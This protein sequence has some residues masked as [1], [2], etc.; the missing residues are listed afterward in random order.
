LDNT[1]Q[2]I[3]TDHAPHTLQEKSQPYPQSPSGLPAVENSLPLMLNQVAQQ[4]CSIEQVASWMCDAPARIW[5][6]VGKGRIEAG[7]DADLVLVD[8]NKQKTIHD[9]EQ[10]TKSKWSPWDGVTLTGWPLATYVGGHKV[11]GDKDGFDETFR[12]S[13]LYFDHSR[14]GYWQTPDGIGTR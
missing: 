4:K 5:G 10:H 3:A 13:H 14:G 6:I 11:Y 7:Y 1:I 12:G 8:L 2:V 9:A